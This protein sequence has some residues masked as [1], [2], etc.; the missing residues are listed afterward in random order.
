ML[1]NQYIR[2]F[3]HAVTLPRR[4]SFQY[5]WVTGCL[6]ALAYFGPDSPCIR[7]APTHLPRTTIERCLVVEG[8]LCRSPHPRSIA[9]LCLELGY[10]DPTAHLGRRSAHAHPELTLARGQEDGGV[11]RHRVILMSQRTTTVASQWYHS[12]IAARAQINL[13]SHRRSLFCTQ[14]QNRGVPYVGS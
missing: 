5:W 12:G 3:S 4:S 2:R 6:T 10:Q 13:T 8:V 14:M 1:H 11:R 9:P 7:S